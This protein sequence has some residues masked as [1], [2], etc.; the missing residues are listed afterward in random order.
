MRRIVFYC[1][2]VPLAIVAVVLSVANRHA[3]TLSFDPF[4]TAAP[5]LSFQV[6]LFVLMFAMLVLGIVVGG[7]AVWISQGRWRRQARDEMVTIDKLQRE[8]D[9][10]PPPAGPALPA[11][12]N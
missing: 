5:A 10:R 2:L 6:P 3:V 4:N 1:V 8:I 9:A 7:L 11:T 12:G